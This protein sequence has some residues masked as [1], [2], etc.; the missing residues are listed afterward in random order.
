MD[1]KHALVDHLYLVYVKKKN[2]V[3]GGIG[4]HHANN[5]SQTSVSV[6]QQRTAFSSSV[7]V[8]LMVLSGADHQLITLSPTLSA[9]TQP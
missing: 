4:V 2:G 3:D 1:F 9:S 8:F 5:V 7:V 6:L